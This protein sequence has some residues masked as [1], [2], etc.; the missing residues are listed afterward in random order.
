MTDGVNVA[1]FKYSASNARIMLHDGSREVELASGGTVTGSWS[2][3]RT[4]YALD[5]GWTAFTR[6]DAQGIYQVWTRSPTG[7]LWQASASGI[8]CN[9]DALGSMGA[10]VYTCGQ[11][12][13]LAEPGRMGQDVMSRSGKVV[14]RDDAFYALQGTAVYRI[15]P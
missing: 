12:R 7:V 2:F 9:L 6:P 8:G 3:P 13:Y 14:W 15:T 5:A 10:V 1:Y 4:A 11:R